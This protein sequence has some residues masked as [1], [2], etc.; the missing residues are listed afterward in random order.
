[1]KNMPDKILRICHLSQNGVAGRSCSSQAFLLDQFGV[2]QAHECLFLLSSLQN[3]PSIAWKSA[4]PSKH[5]PAA[6]CGSGRS[7]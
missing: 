5:V 3:A 6:A 4:F 7:A 2:T 1:M